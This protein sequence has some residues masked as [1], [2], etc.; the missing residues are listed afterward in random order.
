MLESASHFVISRMI[1]NGI[2]NEDERAIYA[3]NLQV[4]IESIV[5]HAILLII[6]TL[7]GHFLDI[8]VFLLSFDLLRRSTGGFHCKTNIGCIT[9]STL[10][11]ILVIVV[12]RFI[13]PI[14]LYYQG[15][16][17]IVNDIYIFG[18]SSKSPQYVLDKR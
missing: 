11:C 14:I 17:D 13:E 7:C 6:A 10:V 9:L 3:Y 1:N 12:Q 15:G 5:G 18:R 4:I 2:I 16:G 8:F